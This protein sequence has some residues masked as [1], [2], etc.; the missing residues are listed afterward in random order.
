[1]ISG[2]NPLLKITAFNIKADFDEYA[3]RYVAVALL[4]IALIALSTQMH[5]IGALKGI[6][7]QIILG[8]GCGLLGLELLTLL[9]RNMTTFH[10]VIGPGIVNKTM[11]LESQYFKFIDHHGKKQYYCWNGT[12]SFY[13]SNEKPEYKNAIPHAIVVK[14]LNLVANNSSEDAV[15]EENAKLCGRA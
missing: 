13:S 8:F 4:A 10:R 7:S 6:N 3:F 11:L 9:Y 12:S 1:M 5:Q 14:S 15:H 2:D